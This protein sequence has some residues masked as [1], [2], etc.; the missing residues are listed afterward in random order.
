MDWTVKDNMLSGLFFAPHLQAAA[1]AAIPHLCNQVRKRVT[2]LWRW[3]SQTQ[4]A[5]LDRGNPGGWVS[6]SEMSTG[7]RSVSNNIPSV[8]CPKLRTSVVV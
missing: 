8:I 6:K 4:A 5:V 1:E 3:S 7:S 2:L